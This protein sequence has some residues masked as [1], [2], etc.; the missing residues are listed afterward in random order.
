MS[1][2]MLAISARTLFSSAYM[3]P[4]SWRMPCISVNRETR[5]HNPPEPAGVLFRCV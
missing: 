5:G 2:R 3:L 4:I 1:S